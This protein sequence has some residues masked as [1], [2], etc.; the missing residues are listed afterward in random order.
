MSNTRKAK[1]A[2]EL[3]KAA[4]L[5]ERTVDICLR[6]D[7]ATEVQSLE[8]ELTAALDAEQNDGRLGGKKSK[9]I[10]ARIEE[11]RA[12]MAESTVSFR[13]RAL[14]RRRWREL[15]DEHP[16]KKGDKGD[17]A[18]G[19]AL[20]PFLDAVTPASV[21]DPELDAAEW[22]ELVDVLSSGEYDRIT[23]AVWDLNRRQVD[24]PK[25]S[26]ASLIARRNDAG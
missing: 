21:V 4:K 8:A 9:Q 6:G 7:L 11:V 18:M 2:K 24:V 20:E 1:S 14:P 22:A 19:V 12:E 10:A 25:S 13:L 3:I 16:P 15:M 17:E 5:P 26:R 23:T